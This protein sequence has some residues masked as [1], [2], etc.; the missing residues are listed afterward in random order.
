MK[1]VI[2]LSLCIITWQQ[3]NSQ[4]GLPLNTIVTQNFNSIGTAAN[5][6]LPANWR[7]SPSGNAVGAWSAGVNITSQAASSG[8]PSS[9][10]RYNWA[11]S[12]GTDRAIGFLTDGA[13]NS[14]NAV[15]AYFRN[16]TGATVSNMTIAYSIERYVVNTTVP[17]VDLYIS[18]NGTTWSSIPSMSTT[19]SDYPSAA[20]AFSFTAPK[21][22]HKTGVIGISLADNADI[23]FRWVFIT[24]N[25]GS[26][27]LGLDNVSIF[28]G[29]ATPVLMANLRDLL[30]VDNGTINQ[31]NEG[32]VIRY[33]TVIKNTGTGNANNVQVTL[34]TP[35]AN[36]TMVAGSI[37]TSALAV[38]D[39]Y[40]AS[41][42]TLLHGTTV[43]ANDIGIPVP[44]AVISYGTSADATVNAPGVATTTDAGG[45]I[46]L[47]ANGAFTYTPPTGFSGIDRFR[48]ITGNG[49]L[50]NNDAFVSITVA[51][52]IS[53]TTTNVNPVCNNGS[54]GSITFNATGG[55]GTLEYSINGAGGP[56]QASNIFTGLS[57]GS[58]NLAVRDA[59]GYIKTGTTSL[60]NPA[61]IVVSGS[62]PTIFYTTA[63]SASTF[64]KTGGT[65]TIT[66]SA[67]GLPSGV[68]I[69]S[70]SG[71]VTGTPAV[72]GVFNATITAT[73]IN[74]CSGSLNVTVNVG[75]KLATDTYGSVVGNTQLVADG[76]STPATPFTSSAVN[77]IAND[78]SDAA[79]TITAVTNAATTSGGTISILSNGKFIYTPP[80]GFTGSDSYTYTG[81]SNTI[82]ATATINFTIANMV[83]YVNNT[84][85]GANGTADGRSHRPFT[86]TTD[87][88][89]VSSVN[90][91]IYVLTGSGNTTGNT[92]LKTGQ[93]L[94]GAGSALSIGALSIAADTKPTL[95][96]TITL[97]TNITADGFDMSTGT[98]TAFTNSGVPVTGVNVN[99]GNVTAT[100]GTGINLTGTG[101]N[102]TMTLAS[103][104]TNGAVNAATLTGTAGTVAI[105]GGSQTGST[106]ATFH[107]GGGT[108]SLTYTGNI[109]QAVNAAVFFTNAGH[110]TGTVNFTTGTINATNGVGLQFDNA[111]G[112]YNF[113]GTTTLNGGDA[114]IDI[115]NGSAGTFNFATTAGSIAITNPSGNGFTISGA[116]N[117]CT[118]NYDGNI[119]K[120]NTGSLVSIAGHSTGTVTF[121]SGNTL[122]ATTASAGNGLQFDNADGTYAFNGTTTLNGGD[123]GIDII[124]GSAGTF[125]FGS[126]TAITNPSGEAIR[127]NASTA[128]VTYSGTFSKNNNAVTG[129]L[130]SSET[131]GTINFNGTGAKLLSTQTANAVNL[132]SNTGA[133]I[134]FSGNNLSLTTT[135]GNG[136][137]ATG[138]GTVSVAGTGNTITSTT[139]IA[140]NVQS[141]TV[142]SSN[143][144]FQSIA[145]N[146]G[147]NGIAMNNTGAAGGLIVTG[148]GSAGSGGT[149]QSTTGDGI[150]IVNIR[151]ISL[152]NMNISNCLGHGINASSISAGTMTLTSCQLT[153]SGNA[154]NE[155]GMNVLNCTGSLTISGSTFNGASE[156]LLHVENTSGTLTLLVQSSSQFT[157]PSAIGGL[158]NCAILIQPGN[159]AVINT[160]IQNTTFTNIKGMAAL[161]AYNLAA[162]NG[163][164]SFTFSNNTS[165]ITLAGRAG[166]I[167][168]GGQENSTTNMT[169]QNNNFSGAGGNGVISVDVNDNSTVSGTIS[170]NTIASPPGIGMFVAVDENA[171]VDVTINSNT[172]TN[173]GGDAIQTVNFGGAGISTM[174][175]LITNNNI[176]GHSLNTSVNFVG[177]ISYVGFE[178]NNCITMRG[179]TVTGTPA[180]PTHCGGAPC[181]DYFMQES[182]GVT[183]FE[184]IPNTGN[185]TLNAAYVNS[186]NDPGSVS[187]FG[188]I[189]LTNGAACNS[190]GTRLVQID[191]SGRMTELRTGLYERLMRSRKM[192]ITK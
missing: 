188:S 58:Y 48:Y 163:T 44:I 165:N 182:A 70:S 190:N 14:P 77:I 15:M 184:E 34:P 27:G 149:I 134:N 12:A 49:N 158:A 115:Y 169:V 62:I 119:S 47:Q 177:A 88:I 94:R 140:L 66:W 136:F 171:H 103:L 26:Q 53:F 20:N 114:G 175:C 139:G 36:T 80:A 138:G 189:D 89:N 176:N 160:T 135:S 7:M 90:Q 35:P 40:T 101:N 166:G 104:T 122:S 57:A 92:V 147:A 75:P 110:A 191:E 178:D 59:G 64:T 74:G 32:D 105:N 1:R 129:I 154:D 98:S 133:T 106:G 146:G 152:T 8:A 69:N 91:T 118:V 167:F 46:T 112:T 81:T 6:T 179:N 82:S 124:T 183:K 111:D 93:T 54:N 60:S 187:V 120:T 159:A 50:P 18:T 143:L 170:G 107:I 78:A 108:V 127:V 84:Y 86:T 174:R 38:D 17:I 185:T 161:F 99:V 113:L 83:W 5:A 30:Q 164:S 173:T 95:S 3:L 192:I 100:T 156:D 79:I 144:N 123:A 45:T 68:S 151:S 55:N 168:V 51:A 73:D 21:T 71:Q 181:D 19:S 132:T 4:T 96:G 11:T 97:A 43:L 29:D 142:S 63:M 39:N 125:T 141:T 85:A 137:N 28:A 37:K 22:I 10:G 155:H 25:T 172:L 42:N 65:G 145:A 130:I 31:F 24:G 33:Q 162:S 61:A 2:F 76:H 157:Y 67:I 52:D 131:G 150:N 148:T 128:N 9:G 13:Y 126:G 186:I 41:F 180:S 153:N 116:A 16:T 117:T 87:A 56:Y 102:V 109:T 121:V 72:T 23:Y